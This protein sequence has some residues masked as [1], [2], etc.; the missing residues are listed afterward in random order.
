MIKIIL[1]VCVVKL[2]LSEVFD[3]SNL[4]AM[5]FFIQFINKSKRLKYFQ[6]RYEKVLKTFIKVLKVF[7]NDVKYYMS[8]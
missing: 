3:I 6:D 1:L 8:T 7:S 5:T 2:I 4:P